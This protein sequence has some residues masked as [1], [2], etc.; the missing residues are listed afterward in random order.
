MPHRTRYEEIA[1]TAME[2][3]ERAGGDQLNFCHGLKDIMLTFKERLEL[4]V[5]ELEPEQREEWNETA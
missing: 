1:Q 4:A 5:S 2:A 3:A